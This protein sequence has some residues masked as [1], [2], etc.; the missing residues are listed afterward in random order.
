ME[1]G[2]VSHM[3]SD[4]TEAIEK[5]AKQAGAKHSGWK[6]AS[7]DPEGLDLT[8]GDDVSR[9]WF[10]APL[11]SAQDLRPVLVALAKKE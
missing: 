1:D 5:Y 9:L 7:L 4:H 6:L 8:S 3:N 10:D 2:A 11:Q